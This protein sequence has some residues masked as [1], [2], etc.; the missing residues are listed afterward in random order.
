MEVMPRFLAV[1]V[2]KK[3]DGS[4]LTEAD[5]AAQAAFAERLPH[6]IDCPMLGEEMST[7]RQH[8]LWEKHSDGLWIVDPIDGTTNFINGLPHFALSV[9]YMQ[10]GISQLGVIYNPISQELFYAQRGCGSYLNGQ[11]LP[12]RC[13]PKPLSEAIAGVEVKYLRSGKLATRMYSLS[14]VN[15]RRSMGCSTLDWCYLAAGRYDVYV[16][17]GQRLWDYAAGALIYEEA[18]GQLATLEGDEFWSGKHVF[19][20]SVIAALQPDLFDRWLKWIR[21]N[22]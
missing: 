22:Q 11:P 12:L 3:H 8:D 21:A 1:S 6:I 14:P 5:I 4:L 10:N 19:Y 15:S 20:R 13:A 16:H 17:G 2:S 9:A 7:E 18:G